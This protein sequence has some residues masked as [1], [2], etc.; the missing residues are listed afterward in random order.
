MQTL[1]HPV[2]G[3]RPIKIGR[4]G[5]IASALRVQP[6][7][8]RE[9][10]R[11]L[12]HAVGA[13]VEADAGIVIAD[14]GQRLAM[15]VG[16][17][18]RDDKLIRHALVVRLLHPLDRVILLSALCIGEY[19]RVIRL[20]NPLP[21]PVAVHRIV[22]AIHRRNLAAAILAHLLQQLIEISRAVGGQGVAPVHEGMHEDALQAILFRHLE[23]RIEMLLLRVHAAVRHQPK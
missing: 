17:D 2:S 6:A 11:N 18:E 19:H 14:G 8:A 16:T 3:N 5:K 15:A 21:A 23:Q 22:A 10:P 12:P 4:A 1:R 9:R 13:E 20:Q 7:I